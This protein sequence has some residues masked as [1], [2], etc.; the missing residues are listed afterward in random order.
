MKF[1]DKILLL[2]GLEDQMDQSL[3]AFARRHPNVLIIIADPYNDRILSA[4]KKNIIQGNIDGNEKVIKGMLKQ[5]RHQFQIAFPKF[6]N[7]FAQ[8]LKLKCKPDTYIKFTRELGGNIR[9]LMYFVKNYKPGKS[10][11]SS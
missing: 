1:K 2:L 8:H 5:S 7:V 11:R 10:K 4:Y 3:K 6:V 9:Q